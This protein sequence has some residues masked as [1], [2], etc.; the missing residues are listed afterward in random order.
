MQAALS[1]RP[2]SDARRAFYARHDARTCPRGSRAVQVT[3]EAG[4]LRSGH[5]AQGGD[6]M[7]VFHRVMAMP[8]HRGGKVFLEP[9]GVTVFRDECS[10]LLEGVKKR[11]NMRWQRND[12]PERNR[13]ADHEGAS[14]PPGLRSPSHAQPH[15]RSIQTPSNRAVKPLASSPPGG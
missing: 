8:M 15:H 11:R 7:I 9:M 10:M 5:K 12:G 13:K 2:W 6:R 4:D 1:W 3:T 14:T